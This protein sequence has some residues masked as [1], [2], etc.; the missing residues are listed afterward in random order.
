MNHV[1]Q[2]LSKVKR[3]QTGRDTKMETSLPTAWPLKQARFEENRLWRTKKKKKKKK[4]INYPHIKKE[5]RWMGEAGFS[6][7]I[8]KVRRYLQVIALETQDICG[9]LI[10]IIR[11]ILS[12][13][14]PPLYLTYRCSQR[15]LKNQEL[16]YFQKQR[17]RGLYWSYTVQQML[18]ISLWSTLTFL[19]KTHILPKL[20]P[21]TAC[22]HY[23][24]FAFS[25]PPMLCHLSVLKLLTHFSF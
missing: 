1:L 15:K 17:K 12:R 6:V 5:V 20:L 24:F 4:S 3:L 19:P 11:A 9:T 16:L 8:Q 7:H 22:L 14:V 10:D 18:F 13:R 21:G 2:V 23:F 25:L